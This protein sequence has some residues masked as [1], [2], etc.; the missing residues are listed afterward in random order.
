MDLLR[1]WA[2]MDHTMSS[3]CMYVKAE[4]PTTSEGISPVT[5]DILE[6]TV[7]SFRFVDYINKE[8]L[9]TKAEVH[10]FS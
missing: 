10:L 2:I 1:R 4:V 9:H 7:H 6:G 5:N 3:G 8:A